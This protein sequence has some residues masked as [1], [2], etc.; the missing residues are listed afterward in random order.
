MKTFIIDGQSVQTDR[1]FRIDGI[2]IP[3]PITY[4]PS[5]EDLSSD[6][7]GRITLTGKM[8]KTV[9]AVKAT[10]KCGWKRLSWQDTATIMN[11]I[12]GK[13]EVNFTHADPRVPNQWITKKFYIG[14]RQNAALD[15]SEDKGF[16]TGLGCSFIEI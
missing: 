8:V 10:Y 9:V 3:T 15:L 2:P 14:Q 4:E 1:P 13:T 16:W 11:A 6:E 7:T 5:I 12:N